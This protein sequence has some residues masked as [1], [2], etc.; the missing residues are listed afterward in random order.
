MVMTDT[1]YLHADAIVSPLGFTT[2]QNFEHLRHGI[3]GVSFV[4]AGV[5]SPEPLWAAC[6]NSE[7]LHK[8]F[9]SLFSHQ[10][11]D[12]YT[13]LE[14]MLLLA[15]QHALNGSPISGSE[16]NTVFIVSTTKGNIDLLAPDYKGNIDKKRA[17]LSEMAA[18]VCHF[19]GNPNQPI[20]VC[21]ACISGVAA[22]EVALRLLRQQ[23]Y[24]HAVVLGGDILSEYVVSGFQSFKATA[25][26]PCRPYDR[27]RNGINLGEG[28]AAMVLSTDMPKHRP[29]LIL[30][31]AGCSNDA[32]HISGPSR[33]GDG[34]HLA[35]QK[36]LK[37]A[38]ITA[39]NLHYLCMHGTATVY[40]DEMESKALHLS[41]LSHVPMHSL[42]GFFGHTLGAAGVIETVIAAESM[43]HSLLIQCLGFQEIGVPET[44]NVITQNRHQSIEFCL[45]TASG[46]GGCN[47]AL[48]L[49]CVY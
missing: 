41:G 27:D 14:Q 20:V 34:L 40:N 37:D 44:V 2:A 8:E 36:A 7:N 39:Q 12:Q 24:R 26:A 28:A 32:N 49:Q 43:R 21:N 6:V 33:T 11:A 1:V 4:E 17:D 16:Q 47:G 38:Q 25:D 18:H 3:S 22:A 23:K 35:I 10:N 5:L 31:G 19:F 15:A 9:E 46:F 29:A 42:K 30:S 45:K 48:V 13:R